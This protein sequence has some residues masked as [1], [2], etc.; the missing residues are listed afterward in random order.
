M[1]K[2]AEI[3]APGSCLNKSEPDEPLFVLCARDP[4]APDAV[5]RWAF[6]AEQQGTHEPA[7][8]E[9]ARALAAQMEEWRLKNRPRVRVEELAAA[10]NRAEGVGET[11]APNYDVLGQPLT[12]EQAQEYAIRRALEERRQYRASCAM[13]S[14]G[15]VLAGLAVAA[16]QEGHKL[17]DAELRQAA[18]DAA[19]VAGYLTDH[20]YA[21]EA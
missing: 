12:A 2:H 20:V 6:I 1:K 18:K 13:M 16:R 3:E 4:I 10:A 8:I 7:K 11:P 21:D 19:T 17:T 15:S 9:E 5:M 14:C